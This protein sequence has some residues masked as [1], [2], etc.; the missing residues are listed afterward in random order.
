[1]KTHPLH[2]DSNALSCLAGAHARGFFPS[3][4][5]GNK[6]SYRCV[7]A[8]CRAGSPAHRRLDRQRGEGVFL[9]GP[10]Q[11]ACV[12]LQQIQQVKIK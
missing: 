2:N 6:K 3:G 7:T 10:E 5:G 1:M 11:K 9:L 12:S 4:F 8:P